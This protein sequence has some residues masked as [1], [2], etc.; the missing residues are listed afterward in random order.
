[1]A[2]YLKTK[3]DR[4]QLVSVALG[5]EDA[6]L[7]IKSGKLVNVTSAETYEVDVAIKGERIALVGEVEHCVGKSTRVHDAR[8]LFL[9]P[10]LI[11]GHVHM[12]ASFLTPAEYAR[13]VVPRGTTAVIFDPSW[14]ANALGARG[15]R[16]IVSKL[17][18]LPLKVFLD[19][20][21]CVPLVPESLLTPGHI[22]NPEQVKDMLAWKTVVGLGELNDWRRVLKRDP[23]L[24]AEIRSALN[25]G[26]IVDG[27]AVEMTG[28]RLNAYV[29]AGAQSDHEAVSMEEGIER[30][31]AGIRLMIREGS[32]EHNLKEVIRVLTETEMDSR[33]CC[34]CTDDKTVGDLVDEGH[35]DHCVRLAIESGVDPVTAIQMATINC[36]QHF[37]LDRELGSISPGKIADILLVRGLENFE[38][39]EVFVNG[40]CVA[41]RGQPLFETRHVRYPRY[42]LKT[43]RVG[44]QLQP[45]DFEIRTQRKRRTKV[46]VI[47]VQEDQIVT[48]KKTQTLVVHKGKILPDAEKDVCKIVVVERYGRTRLNIGKGFVAGF[49]LN[50]GCL[51]SSISTDTHHIVSIGMSDRDIAVAVNQVAR[52]QGGIVVVVVGEVVEELKLPLAGVMSLETYEVVT[53]RLFRLHKAARSLGCRLKSP[54]MT[55][56]F[57]T[58][59]SLTEI[60]ITDKG[61]VEMGETLIPLEVEE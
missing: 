50:R 28:E 8:G 23:T 46:W 58:N 44:R 43:F 15:L 25:L 32:S 39:S 7:V 6:D 49:G 29:A 30:V 41:R 17:R 47:E 52:E 14:L 22:L 20:P 59:P 13:V 27:N 11:D 54:F 3:V 60:K 26:K 12:E 2:I 38:V 18:H 33:Y 35:I 37:E 36:A 53:K 45:Q 19:V 48:R 5:E 42:A 61:L 40:V 51:A 57:T 4:E 21:S 34:L 16:L 10:G 9:V 55:L 24:H 56:S 1:M 31:R